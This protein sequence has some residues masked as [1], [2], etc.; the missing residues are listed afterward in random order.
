MNGVVQT[1]YRYSW[2]LDDGGHPIVFVQEVNVEGPVDGTETTDNSAIRET[3]IVKNS[4]GSSWSFGLRK[5]WDWQIG[6]DDGPWFAT[7]DH[8]SEGCDRSMTFAADGSG[9]G[10]YPVNYVMNPDPLDAL[11]PNGITPIALAGCTGNPIY[12]VA[13]TVGP[14]SSLVPPPTAPELLMFNSWP[15]LVDTCWMP[16]LV[17]YTR[18]GAQ[19]SA[20]GD[21]SAIAYFYGA[22]AASA[23]VVAA[24]RQLSFTE[25]V[26]AASNS[27]PDVIEEPT[28]HCD[29][30]GPYSAACTGDKA[31]LPLQASASVDSGQVLIAWTTDC[32]NGSFDDAAAEDPVL[33]LDIDACTVSCSVTL[34]V[35]S[36][37]GGAPTS[38]TANVTVADTSAPTLSC[39]PDI[40]FECANGGL[41]AA[42]PG[43][44][45]WLDAATAVDACGVAHVTNDLAAFV[46]AAGCSKPIVVTFTAADDCGNTATCQRTLTLADTAAPTVTPPQDAFAPCGAGA[47]PAE[48]AWL[49]GASAV[50]ACAGPLP[51]THA[52]VSDTVVCGASRDRVWR[53][54]AADACGNADQ[55]LATFQII[56][57]EPPQLSGVPGNQT[58]ACDA[59]P[60]AAHPT[61]ADD[62]DPNP[63]IEL[64]ETSQ[65]GACPQ[66]RVITR[67]WTAHDACGNASAS[68]QTI[69]VVDDIAPTLSGVPANQTVACN[70]I[71]AAPS[72]TAADACDPNPVVSFNE[73]SQPGACPQERTILRTWTARDACGNQSSAT[74]AITVVDDVAPTLSGV[75]ANQTV[76]CDA[77]PGV[78]SPTASD[79][80]DPNP[81]VSFTESSQPG[82]CPQERVITRR[83]TARDACGNQSS[84]TQQITVVDD[85]APT[86][87]GVPANQTVAC[88]A[89]PAAASPTASDACDP[90]P[91]IS[92]SETSQGGACPQERVITRRWTAR[93]ACG[94]QSSA[95]QQIT[96]VDD[97]APVLSGVPAN[98]TVA[99]DAVP[100]AASPTAS[101]ACDPD[102]AVTFDETSQGGACPQERVITRTWTARDAC[103]NA[104]T[105]T[106]RITVVDDV[107]PVLT[108]VPGDE[109]VSCDA[110]IPPAFVQAHDAC[111]PNPVLTPSQSEQPGACPQERILVRTWTARDACGNESTASQT[112]TIVDD[113]APVI[114]GA[115]ADAVVACNAVPDPPVLSAQDACDPAPAVI[116]SERDLPAGAG[117]CPDERVIERTWI[118]RDACGNESSH[119]QVITTVDNVA[120]TLAGVPA[121][122]RVSC[123]AVPAAANVSAVD[124]CDP[125]P[126]VV[127]SEQHLDDPACPQRYSLV[128]TW[129]ASDRCGNEASREQVITVVDETPPALLG[130]PADAVVACNDVPDPAAVHASDACDPAPVVSLDESVVPGRC[131]NERVITRTWTARDAC[132]NAVNAAQVLTV[133]DELPPTLTPPADLTVECPE[134]LAGP[135]SQAAWLASA[136][137]ADGCGAARVE[138][139][140]VA[141]VAGCGVTVRR[142][143]E[144]WA[145]DACDNESPHVVRAYAVVDTTPPTLAAPADAVVECPA[146]VSGAG[147]E[148]AWLAS[149]SASDA[150]GAATIQ[151]RILENVAGCG[152][153]FRHAWE[154]WAVDACGLE[155]PRVRRSFEVVDTTPPTLAAPADAAVE[156]PA[157]ASGPGS[158]NAW[159]ASASASDACGS[160][161][162]ERNLIA[163]LPGCG[164]TGTRVWEMWAV[165]ACG[166]ESSRVQRRFSVQDTTPPVFGGG[167]GP[168]F[169][170]SLWPPNHGY[171]VFAVADVASASDAC[172]GIVLRATGCSSDQPEDVQGGSADD[173]A[174]GDGHFAEDCVLA[175]DGTQFAVRAERLGSCGAD[176]ARSY[177]IE[178]TA[179]DECGNAA[180]ALGTVRV[181]HDR[182]GQQSVRQ[183]RKLGPNDPPPFP[184]VHDTTY[185]QGC[186]P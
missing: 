85:T 83:W 66:E 109:Q 30:G 58:V 168:Q 127:E 9:A 15:E 63:A 23:Q 21:D 3:H 44:R 105:A 130:V 123:D 126:Q 91:V 77:I 11:C 134:P 184:Y 92:F 43:V 51:V 163:D 95:T 170:A 54:S 144:L 146:P 5:H 110:A 32:P 148:A 112:V 125:S 68:T 165:D 96:V 175:V 150:C 113:E 118:A 64:D 36:S 75:P 41:H 158:E 89:V 56:D 152:L 13:G 122:A 19:G 86:L 22:T 179:T 45:A 124:D 70:A 161:H 48:Q 42:D 142:S 2:T 183:G 139:R 166:L 57:D 107:A 131:P 103:G 59:V 104:S 129:T 140:L 7:C 151:S 65:P 71:P 79:A 121:D 16:A 171:V 155:S 53:F 50:D 115:P 94:N 37:E 26:V 135:S 186:G 29:A 106:Q 87:T 119:V 128:R 185:G 18:C 108:G 62:C 38:C 141:E 55:A 24:H 167:A 114:L 182:S 14:P 181:E 137:A 4:G 12:I 156:C 177:A 35:S 8:V 159:L 157:P 160:A 93:D 132:G 90:S 10:M 52:L 72:P 138:V 100:A 164:A 67:T 169:T 88:D 117:A 120:P 97:V 136:S 162:V 69:T 154:I 172:G 102:P 78:A 20:N 27:C 111:D 46:P 174:N 25:Y 81:S 60:A 180:R 116:F 143:W 80:C 39:P 98:Q 33:S 76:A 101:D 133:L 47:A 1:G 40:S 34:T 145:V 17:D 84:A 173:G 176:S 147:S 61:A 31:N 153:T 82:G 49:A 99:C 6:P 149:A 28:A 74:Q 178:L 73:S